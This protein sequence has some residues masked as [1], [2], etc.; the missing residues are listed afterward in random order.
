MVGKGRK[1]LKSYSK[2]D[3]IL[4]KVLQDKARRVPDKV[5]I[6]TRNGQATYAEVDSASNRFANLLLRLGLKKNDKVCL[7]LNNGLEHIYCWFGCS[8]IGAVDVPIN[9]DYKGQI[10]EYIIDNSDASILVVDQQYI[11]RIKFSEAK[12]KKLKY[13]L[14]V[15]PPGEEEIRFNLPFEVFNLNVVERE[16]DRLPEAS[17]YYYDIE[18]I[19]YTSGTTGP[20]KGVMEPYA[21]CYFFGWQL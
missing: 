12:L 16:S 5:F 15:V 13:I 20:S 19:I 11:E 3:W 4:G 18:T 7:M 6:R 21:Q 2:S 14:V 17:V 1:S 8:K 10:L 9:V